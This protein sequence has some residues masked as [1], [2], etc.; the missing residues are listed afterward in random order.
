M[1][2]WPGLTGPVG[3]GL[4]FGLGGIAALGLA[5]F[6]AWWAAIFSL[7]AIGWLFGQTVTGRQAVRLGWLYGFGYF[8]VGLIWIVEPFLVDL[9]RHGWMAPFGFVFMAGGLALFWMLAFGLAWRLSGV[10]RWGALAL[11]WTLAEFARAYFFTGFPWAGLA[12]IW[13]P[14]DTAL[15]LAWVGPHGLALWTLAATLSL[16]EVLRRPRGHWIA[17]IPAVALA[18]GTLAVSQT[19]PQVE[20]TGKHVRL[21]QPDAPQHLKWHP[22]YVWS[23]FDRALDLTA[24]GQA[25]PRADLIVWPETSIPPALNRAGREVLAIAEQ[26]YGVPVI[27]GVRRT[28]GA[29]FYNSL[30]LIDGGGAVTGRYDKH[31]LV[32][33]G[34]YMPLSWLAARVGL[35]GLAA[36]G[37]GYSA[38]PGA[39]VLDLPGIGSA[40]PLICYEVVFPQD[41]NAA[42]GRPE[43]LL[44]ITNDAWFG[45][46][47]GPYQHLA[48]ARMRAIEQ[49]LPMVRAANTGVSAMIDPLGRITAAVPLNQPGAV[50]AALPAPLVPTVYARTG[51]WPV[52]LL[53]LFMTAV[54][55]LLQVRTRRANRD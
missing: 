32:P 29:R 40:L 30:I 39:Q 12:Q 8:A 20:Q 1:S 51:D 3:I 9:Q 6:E 4:P 52:F 21:V 37:D 48:Q 42:P 10:L 23:F 7:I 31:H 11:T 46:W 45:T 34:E 17:V 54:M 50:T 44:Q 26:A 55:V 36:D 41:V 53:A 5:P 47:S 27:A 18:L 38:G 16:P 35:F 15:L 22:D 28:E 33:F 2:R 13:V 14:T 49:G 24:S 19:V 43:M 25:D